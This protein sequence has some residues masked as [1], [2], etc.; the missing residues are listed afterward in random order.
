MELERKA[1]LL[2]S[3]KKREDNPAVINKTK[4]AVKTLRTRYLVEI[5]AV[6]A[7]SIEV[8]TLRDHQLDPQLR[9]LVKE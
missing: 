1:E 7:A 4:A 9:A 2:K 6:D 8:D 3:Q 5:Q